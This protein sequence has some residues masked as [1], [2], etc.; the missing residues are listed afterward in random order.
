MEDSP[1]LENS[2]LGIEVKCF[3]FAF[4]TLLLSVTRFYRFQQGSLISVECYYMRVSM[5]KGSLLLVKL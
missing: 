2:H 1:I 5:D 4:F 3:I